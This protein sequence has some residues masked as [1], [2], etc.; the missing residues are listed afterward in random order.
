[1]NHGAG[2][3][4]AAAGSVQAYVDAGA[5]AWAAAELA[6]AL[7]AVD[8]KGLGG[9]RL[10]A[11]AGEL[12]A[13]WLAGFEA[14]ASGGR[15]PVVAPSGVSIERLLGGVSAEQSV[16]AGRVV[17][18]RGLLS[19]AEGRCFVLRMAERVDPQ[20]AA[21]IAAGMDD[22]ARSTGPGFAAVLLDEGLAGEEAPP[23]VLTDRLAFRVDLHAA[24]LAAFQPFR[25]T[26]D[27]IETA[28][29]HWPNVRVPDAVTGAL[30]G[31]GPSLGVPA[32]RPALFALA[33]AKAH[34]ALHGRETVSDED[35]AVACRLVFAHHAADAA[36]P[37]AES[38]AQPEADGPGASDVDSSDPGDEARSRADTA[39]EDMLIQTVAAS[40]EASVLD[41][42]S[43]R[44][45]RSARGASGRSGETTFAADRGRPDRP[46]P[47]R[48]AGRL[49][50][51][52]PLRSAAPMQRIRRRGGPSGR[53]IVR[54]SDFRMKRFRRRR[55]SSVIFVVD[56]SG[57]S[58]MQRMAEA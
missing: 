58:A 46:A 7:V 22:A 33:A 26:A 5:K 54:P 42:P 21:V 17:V 31:V 10:A 3:A 23:R 56:A 36:Q 43:R 15:A 34:A 40:I 28:R 6:A 25:W 18:E 16:S 39:L 57:S 30:A 24:P 38:A 8:P 2:P 47:G 52:A 12:R 14:L 4:T 29:A 27:E 1:M 13:Q 37:E 55:Q 49:D 45:R 41:T 32:L 48:R 50:L 51:M 11:P 53:L 44:P 20:V 19:Q 9:V 35:A